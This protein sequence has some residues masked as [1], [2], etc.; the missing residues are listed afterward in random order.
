[1][2]LQVC[3]TFL[4]PKTNKLEGIKI[5]EKKDVLKNLKKGD[6]TKFVKF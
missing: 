4:L 1:M 6:F 2:K 5:L 3:M